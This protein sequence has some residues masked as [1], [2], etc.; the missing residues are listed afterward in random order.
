VCRL[1]VGSAGAFTGSPGF[2]FVELD[3]TRLA[4]YDIKRQPGA[5]LGFYGNHFTGDVEAV[6][7]LMALKQ[8]M[9]ASSRLG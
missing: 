6:E 8:P 3:I 2:L 5:F 7:R 1:E 4:A 9:A